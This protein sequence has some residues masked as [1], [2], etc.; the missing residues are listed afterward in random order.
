MEYKD[1]YKT[2]GVERNASADEIKKVYRK[3]A[4]KYHPDVSKEANAEE[5]FKEV[6]EAYEVLRDSEKRRA[7][8]ELGSNW[9]AGQE[10]RPPPGWDREVHFHSSGG[11][12]SQ[13]SDFFEQLFGAHGVDFGF[14]RA[15][16]ARRDRHS[17]GRKGN[18]REHA[19]TISLEEAYRGGVRTIQLTMPR[20]DARGR[21][22]QDTRT[23]NVRIP[24]GVSNG[25]R[26]RL[27]GQ[28]DAGAGGGRAGDLYFRVSI[29]PHRVYRLDGRNIEL[30][31]PISP[32]EAALGARIEVPTP[33]GR[34]AMTVPAGSQSGARFRLKGRGL[35]GKEPGDF[36]VVLKIVNPPMEG[37]QVRE[38]YRRMAD[39]I[40]FDPRA[41]LELP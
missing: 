19:I 27:G 39:A 28:G 15:G 38:L 18:D 7:Y 9:R 31:L 4:R 13:F 37:Q 32:W 35:P 22:S 34:A 25:Q 33:G 41:N 3:L 12:G 5:R 40:D 26:I 6:Q 1:Y 11:A 36:Y 10:F 17:Q 30:D 16:G 2:L 29:E 21:V 14:D 24:P 23:L 20:R 8:D